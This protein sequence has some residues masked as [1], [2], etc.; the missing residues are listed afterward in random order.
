MTE[1]SDLG[2]SKQPNRVS[3]NGE[4]VGEVE[5][6]AVLKGFS[7]RGLLKSA[8]I[9]WGRTL[10][11]YELIASLTVPNVHTGV[12]LRVYRVS[13]FPAEALGYP[14]FLT[15]AVSD[16]F[17]G[18]LLHELDEGLW[19][20]GKPMREPHPELQGHPRMAEGRPSLKPWRADD[21]RTP[22]NS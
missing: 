5:I 13:R 6:E 2:K 18:L 21:E 1:G 10:D 9:D 14:G 17:R 12:P 11:G 16:M 19:L 3:R 15:C 7:F 4:K 22:T 20:D 8:H